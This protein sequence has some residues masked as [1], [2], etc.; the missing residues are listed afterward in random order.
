[1]VIEQAA[2]RFSIGLSGC[3]QFLEQGLVDHLSQWMAR[4]RINISN[5]SRVEAMR[6]QLVSK[7]VNWIH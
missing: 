5:S 7:H 3:R 1:M 4:V 6:G 2:L